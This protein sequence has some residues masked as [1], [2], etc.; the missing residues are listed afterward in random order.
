MPDL[1]RTNGLPVL[2]LRRQSQY[3]FGLL[4]LQLKLRDLLP[5]WLLPR[6]PLKGLHE[7]PCSVQLV[8]LVLVLHRLYRRALPAKQWRVHLLPVHAEPVPRGEA[9]PRMLRLRPELHDVYG[10]D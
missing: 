1:L 4:L 8:H 5:R 7:L 2:H 9:G 3:W 10:Y 6:Q